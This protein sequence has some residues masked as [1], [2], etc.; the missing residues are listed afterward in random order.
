MGSFKKAT[1]TQSRLRLGISGPAGSGKT[2]SALA[3]GTALL[4]PGG[5][6]AVVDTERGSA[7]KYAHKFEFDVCELASFHPD[8]YCKVI[9]EAEEAGY[10]VIVVDSMSHAWSG[11]GGILEIVDKSGK[12]ADNAKGGNWNG[13]KVATPIQN[14]MVD[15]ILRS[16]AHII[17]TMRSKI[18]W[19]LEK[20][21]R[22]KMEPKK[23]GTAP[24]QRDSLDYEFDVF[25]EMDTANQLTISKTR[26][27]ELHDAAFHKPGA[28]VARILL[29]WLNEGAPVAPSLKLATD[30][31]EDDVPEPGG[32]SRASSMILRFESTVTL[33]DLIACQPDMKDWTKEEKQEVWPHYQRRETFLKAKEAVKAE[34]AAGSAAPVA[35]P[36]AAVSSPAVVSEA[37]KSTAAVTEKLP[38]VDL[39]TPFDDP[40]AGRPDTAPSASPGVAAPLGRQPGDDSEAIAQEKKAPAAAA[41]ELTPAQKEQA[42]AKTLSDKLYKTKTVAEIDALLPE[43]LALSKPMQSQLRKPFTERKNGFIKEGKHA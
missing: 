32:R 35:Q 39:S 2:Y 15:T 13:W 43:F 5:K 19:S 33:S 9:K 16:K 42:A 4:P 26:C 8:E 37:P 28:E 34:A 29:K 3:I 6:M 40:E 30:P 7:S 17:C 27:E 25:G 41:P 36:A 11:P 1:K 31:A 22:G 21:D 18:E 12:G 24:V 10:A 38:T 23:I 20:N 14:R